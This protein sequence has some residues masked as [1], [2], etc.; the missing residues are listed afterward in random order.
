MPGTYFGPYGENN[1]TYSNGNNANIGV[2]PLG[3]RLIIPDGRVYRF[4]LN[5]GTTEVA[6][7]LYQSI[8]PVA[9]HT[10]QTADVTRAAGATTVSA[11]LGSTCAPVDIYAEGTVH[12]NNDAGEGYTYRI[13]RAFTIG[14]AHADAERDAVLTVEL[15]PSETVQ[16]ELGT[17]SDVTFTRNRFHQV[18]I[19]PSPPTSVLAGV[20]PGVCVADDFY[21]SQVHGEC[22]VLAQG[23]LLAAREVQAST[24]TNGAV[25]S[26]KR[27][28][29][30]GGT[31]GADT[32]SG[33]V[34]LD[35]S[36]SE[37]KVRFPGGVTSTT[38][39][40]TGPIANRGPKIGV[41][42]KANA[43]GEMALIDLLYMGW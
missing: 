27:R 11:T 43:N 4:T 25:E 28:Y 32:G 8:A 15:A 34:A 41:C 29:T 23:V 42:V 31:A 21:W 2:W 1:S 40:L 13:R 7:R 3:H 17:G 12:S 22:A 5:D 33:A 39:D 36:G 37:T 30:M 9:N 19:H 26:Y 38:Y 16:V 18:L 35:S 10:N 24:T 14:H 6:G 20:S